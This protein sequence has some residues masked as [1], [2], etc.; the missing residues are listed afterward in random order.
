M[1]GPYEFRF[2]RRGVLYLAE[3]GD[4]DRYGCSRYPHLLGMILAGS[5]HDEVVVLGVLDDLPKPVPSRRDGADDVLC[6]D[7]PPLSGNLRRLVAYPLAPELF[8][9]GIAVRFAVEPKPAIGPQMKP[10]LICVLR[11]HAPFDHHGIDARA[12]WEAGIVVL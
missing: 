8:L 4:Q 3:N 1:D 7:T 10:Y 6:H 9:D 2:S 5:D 11:L 12:Q